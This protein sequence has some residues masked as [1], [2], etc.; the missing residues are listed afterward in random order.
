[1][2]IRVKSTQNDIMLD[3]NS[4]IGML[5]LEIE[6]DEEDEKVVNPITD[7]PDQIYSDELLKDKDDLK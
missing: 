5:G 1:M 6:F 2:A 3:L 7:I 4:K